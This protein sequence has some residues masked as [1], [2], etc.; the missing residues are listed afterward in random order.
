M[1]DPKSRKIAGKD[2]VDSVEINSNI[3]YSI[4]YD[5]PMG[6]FRIVDAVYTKAQKEETAVKTPSN[7]SASSSNAEKSD[8]SWIT[9]ISKRIRTIIDGIRFLG[10]PIQPELQWRDIIEWFSSWI[11]AHKDTEEN[12]VGF[13]IAEEKKQGKDGVYRLVQGVF[14]KTTNKVEEARRIEAKEVDEETLKNCFTGEK[15]TIFN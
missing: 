6:D 11:E 5:H 7:E 15:V 3:A 14:N 9:S 10:T 1:N 2:P 13:T 4:K 8:D 12:F